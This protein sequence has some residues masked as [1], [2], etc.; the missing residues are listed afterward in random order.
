MR[1]KIEDNFEKFKLK[2]LIGVFLLGVQ[3]R[4]T[5]YESI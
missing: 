3:K 5:H 4:A 2:I 1:K